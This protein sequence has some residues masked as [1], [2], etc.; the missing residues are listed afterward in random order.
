MDNGR[1]NWPDWLIYGFEWGTRRALLQPEGIPLIALIELL[2]RRR[3]SVRG[4]P[5]PG[6][7]V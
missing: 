6:W 5:I 7:V 1:F 2:P 3:A 4:P